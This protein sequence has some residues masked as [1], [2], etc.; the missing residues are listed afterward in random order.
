M[1]T[2]SNG[3][4]PESGAPYWGG[5]RRRRAWGATS[6]KPPPSGGGPQGGLAG[7]FQG[8][9]A[10][11]PLYTANVEQKHD[12]NDACIRATLLVNEK[13]VLPKRWSVE[14]LVSTEPRR[15]EGTGYAEGMVLSWRGE[16]N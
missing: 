5:P 13:R 1:Q 9:R 11:P 15:P 2:T 4:H 10:G 8:G 12:S 16:V 3:R 6:P 14:R 7:G